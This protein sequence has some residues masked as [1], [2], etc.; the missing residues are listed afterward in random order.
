[1]KKDRAICIISDRN[2]IFAIGAFI[3]NLMMFNVKYDNIV[4]Y[5]YGFN[6]NDKSIIHK[7]DEKCIFVEYTKDD[8]FSEFKVDEKSSSKIVQF[9][10]RYSHLTYI[11]FKVLEQ[12]K[13]YKTV[14]FC[15]LDVVI[16]GDLDQLFNFKEDIAW[17]NGNPFGMKFTPALRALKTTLDKVSELKGI[18]SDFPT[19]NGGL[20]VLNDTFDYSRALAIGKEFISKYITYF[21]NALDELVFAYITFKLNLK[22]YSLDVYT[23]NSFP[24]FCNVNTKI[25]HC[26]GGGIKPWNNAF[27]Q[28]IFPEWIHS[29]KAF[30]KKTRYSSDKVKIFDN[31]GSAIIN[32]V[33]LEDRWFSVLNKITLPA[34]LSLSYDFSTELLVFKYNKFLQFEIKLMK[35]EFDSY[36]V[37][38]RI[39]NESMAENAKLNLILNEIINKN[40]S[41]IQPGVIYSKKISSSKIQSFFDYL[42]FASSELRS[43]LNI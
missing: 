36:F 3:N 40:F 31:I 24:H 39:T 4:I 6:D 27:I 33:L 42:W 14:L 23:Y 41:L 16:R 7:V 28:A 43:F 34:G 22:L 18:T 32:R 25:V 8:F 20:V 17:R 13:N 26:I 12:L 19:P 11:K 38:A 5:C 10:N 2:Y 1:M 37:G 35:W 21:P 29:Y 15:D 30:V 9:I